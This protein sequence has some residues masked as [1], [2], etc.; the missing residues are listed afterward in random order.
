MHIGNRIKEVLK[1]KGINQSQLAEKMS[2]SR[3]MVSSLINSE[4]VTTDTLEKIIKALDTSTT[5]FFDYQYINNEIKKLNLIIKRYR[6]EIIN[7]KSYINNSAI[8]GR[9]ATLIKFDE[10][11]FMWDIGWGDLKEPISIELY[12]S[13]AEE[14]GEE[15]SKVYKDYEDNE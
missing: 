2:V 9:G 4:S 6:H 15:I 1:E 3:Q 11:K 5:H 13:I 12:K 8:E 14:I 7:L 10:D